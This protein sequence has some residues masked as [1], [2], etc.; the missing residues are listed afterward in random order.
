MG[1]LTTPRCCSYSFICDHFLIVFQCE[2]VLIERC[3]NR[4]GHFVKWGK[5][6]HH[7]PQQ[8][9]S[10]KDEESG[11]CESVASFAAFETLFEGKIRTLLKK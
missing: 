7:D 3:L 10:C 9:N 1:R 5:E 8:K 2:E 4:K 6:C 11:G